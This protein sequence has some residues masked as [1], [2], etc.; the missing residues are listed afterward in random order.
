MLYASA[1]NT[2]DFRHRYIAMRD[3]R[4]GFAENG[5]LETMRMRLGGR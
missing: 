3:N 2:D 5:G 4:P 1:E